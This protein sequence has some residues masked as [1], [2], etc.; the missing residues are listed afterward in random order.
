[1]VI[2]SADVL[3]L[4]PLNK[5]KELTAAILVGRLRQEAEALR[6]ESKRNTVSGIHKSVVLKLLTK[7][8][9]VEKHFAGL[10]AR[11]ENID[12]SSWPGSYTVVASYF[13]CASPLKDC[14]PIS[15]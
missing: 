2:S 13:M 10:A 4:I 8:V 6:K 12:W 1:M 15:I 14:H 11:D 5:K 3:Q 9:R 7:H